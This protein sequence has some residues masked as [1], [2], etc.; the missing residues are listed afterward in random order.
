MK[1]R[2]LVLL[3]RYFPKASANTICTQN[4]LDL[5]PK[6]NY[7]V[8]I[9]CYDD[10]LKTDT[11]YR[12]I[13]LSR[14]LLH[15]FEYKLEM[16][17][18]KCV[19]LLKNVVKTILKLQQL[20]F[21]FVWPWTDPIFTSKVY[22][23]AKHLYSKHKYDYVLAI[24][25][26]LSSIIVG[27]KLKRI[28]PDMQFIP[29]FWDS[30][31]GGV[32]ISLFSLEW[33]T[34]KKLK[35]EQKLLSNA[36][37]IVVMES[38]RS[39]HKKY[40]SRYDYYSRFIFLD[41]PLLVCHNYERYNSPY[42]KEKTNI[43]FCGTANSPLRNIEFFAKLAKYVNKIDDSIVFYIIGKC[44]CTDLFDSSNIVYLKEV[45][46]DKLSPY[47]ACSDILLNFGVK[48]PAAISGKIFEYMGY[49]KPIISTYSIDDEACL[50]YL[51]KYPN[52]LLLNENDTDF[53]K[54]AEILIDYAHDAITKKIEVEEIKRI[55]KNNMPESFISAVFGED[56]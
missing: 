49:A 2:V 20:P 55:F 11:N 31:S 52:A 38:S 46:H 50:P 47:I 32:P 36:D 3:G 14:G 45:P 9:I 17:N 39:H 23:T 28:Y 29:V 10:G 53:E 30:L 54:Q 12:V 16:K 5:L 35:W 37:K 56:T 33:N 42:R 18:G 7:N 13:K 26:P 22:N 19:S 34:R 51:K 15:S 40:S 44:N 25:M 48:T 21:L 27:N 6:D 4:V 41:I 43:V 8:D 24:H 1:K